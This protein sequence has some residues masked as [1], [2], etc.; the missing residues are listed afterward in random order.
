MACSN[1]LPDDEAK[2]WLDMMVACP[3]SVTFDTAS[4]ARSFLA[5]N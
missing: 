4:Y 5:R 2:K 1:D 3:T